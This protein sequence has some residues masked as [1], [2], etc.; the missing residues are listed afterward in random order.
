MTD[1][2]AVITPQDLR[3]ALRAL[4]KSKHL[5]QNRIVAL[6][7][8]VG[9]ELGKSTLSN[10]LSGVTHLPRWDTVE[11]ILTACQVTSQ[12]LAAWE[13]AYQ[14]A[15]Q[16]EVGEPLTEQLDPIELG[17]HKPIT[18]SRPWHDDGTLTP[19]VPRSHDI[20]LAEIVTAVGEGHSRFVLLLGDSSTGKTR[21]LWEALS[22][23]RERGGWRL[24]H[25]TSPDRR[26]ALHE[27]LGRVRP[28]TVLWLNESQEYLGGD[29]RGGDEKAAVALRELLRDPARAPV[30]IVGTLWREYYTELRSPHAS[31][32]RDLL[33][34]SATIL[35]VPVSFTDADPETLASAAET[36]PRFA[37]ASARAE[38]GRITQYL[39][40]GPELLHRYE[41]E[42]SAVA[43]AIVQIAMD[44]R[45]M[46]HR[47]AIP[48]GLL[49]AATHSYI[50]DQW[51]AVAA[52]P[53][54]LEQALAET[55][56]PCKGA[57]GPL[58][59]V[60]AA[61]TRSH[62]TRSQASPS[63]GANTANGPVYQLADYL[64]QHGRR[65]ERAQIIPPIEFWEA[66]TEYAHPGDR[67]VLGRAARCR[68]LYRDAAQ[69]WVEAARTGNVTAAAELIDL[70]R[71][72][73][74]RD[75]RPTDWVINHINSDETN[76]PEVG[77]L[78]KQLR[79]GGRAD[80]ARVLAER[81][82]PTVVTSDPAEIAELLKELRE[83][84][85][86][87]Q[88]RVLAER[89]VSV[90]DLYN[91]PYSIAELLTELREGGWTDQE[92]E[93]VERAV[94][95][96]VLRGNP[97]WV[98]RLLTELREGGWTDQERELVECAV[99]AVASFDGAESAAEL[100][101]GLR[102]GGWTDQAR[103]LVERALSPD[104]FHGPDAPV[105]TEALLYELDE[106]E[107]TDKAQE[108][109]DH[110]VSNT[111]YLYNPAVLAWLL[112]VLRAQGLTDLARIPVEHAVS[113]ADLDDS[114][115][116][117]QMLE[118]LLDGGWTDQAQAMAERA[119]AVVDL[120]DAIG[121]GWLLKFLRERGLTDQARALAERAVSDTPPNALI[122]PVE[123][124]Q[125]L[126]DGK[127]TDQ[128][129][130]LNAR[131]PAVGS[132]DL[133]LGNIAN[134]EDFRFG[135]ETDGTGSPEWTWDDLF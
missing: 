21:A 32:V 118:A 8:D 109:F 76:T 80:Q 98:G 73:H 6:V 16:D 77:A 120:F 53:D 132:F 69:L 48:H 11:P 94:S 83:G 12:E 41:H 62:R 47:N 87:D 5:S 44:A 14:R 50:P 122:D 36:D 70:L 126:R 43:K 86:T 82:A 40:G 56:R 34:N 89:A 74:P 46:G 117:L 113:E 61:P 130:K 2:D 81:A 23:L 123:L 49:A 3:T 39:A 88:A 105:G 75:E 52:R 68:G 95:A 24:W 42:L 119:V 35:E 135:R 129:Q 104:I 65:T 66:L 20:A 103:E 110:A 108:L 114:F 17:V 31:Q 63:A 102:E 124:V 26:T 67:A 99:P 18:I 101:K 60:A 19:Y 111:V 25:P 107:W 13:H 134:P 28:R 72:V 9:V 79:K 131:L 59:R 125:E 78:L 115:G 1:I 55:A 84:G 45:H 97:F 54:W 133:F 91:R 58:A 92:R 15:S 100:L 38:H 7:N 127:W 128:T 27:N 90:A 112:E 85:W 51:N 71:V 57:D 64:D 116:V 33:A 121:I 10:I 93:L 37:V 22:P 96:V 30:L 29:G 106:G 4:F